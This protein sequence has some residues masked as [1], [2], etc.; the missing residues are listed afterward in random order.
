M[1]ELRGMMHQLLQRISP[2]E[3]E[4]SQGRNSNSDS[5][6]ALDMDGSPA[7]TVR[8]LLD[9][10][11]RG[12]RM[13]YLVDWEGYGPEECS[14]VPAE[15]LLDPSLITDFHRD[16]TGCPAPRPKGRPR[17]RT[18]RASG[19]ARQGGVMSHPR[20]LLP[21]PAHRGRPHLSSSPGFPT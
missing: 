16:H 18:F 7:Y 6:L 9:S 1:E 15:D 19:A 4:T 3:P 11:R 2:S 5:P 17:R 20:L 14:W 8:T 21:L 13:F 12:R 10:R